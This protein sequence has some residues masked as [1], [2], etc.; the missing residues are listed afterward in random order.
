M[1]VKYREEFRTY[2]SVTDTIYY[3]VM[4]HYQGRTHS[5]DPVN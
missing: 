5:F 1:G 4:I 3:V 2:R